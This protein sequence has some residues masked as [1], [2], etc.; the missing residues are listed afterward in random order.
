MQLFMPDN[1]KMII[2]RLQEAGYEAYAVGGCVRDSYLGK[3]PHDWDIT[4][5]ALPLEVKSLFRRTID[6]GIQHGTVKIMI[7]DEGYEVTTY[8]IDGEYEDNRHP[9][10]VIFTKSLEEDLK[11]R[12]FTINAMAYS[13]KTGIIDLFGGIEDLKI[14][15]IRA[16]GDPYERFSEDALRI[17]RALR[18]SAKFSFVIETKTR[19]A[20][21]ELA[22]TLSKI[23]AERIREEL[24]KMLMT[25]NPDRL[26]WAYELGVSK[27]IFPEWDDMM[28]CGQNTP[29]H[30][31]SAG[32]HTL[33]VIESLRD[34]YGQEPLYDQRILRIAGL[35]HDIAKPIMKTT[36][37]NGVDHF[38]GHPEKGVDLAKVILRRLKYDNDTIN[39]VCVLIKYHDVR[40]ILDL[41][42]VRKV[43]VK[44]GV[45]NF[46][47]LIKLKWADL[48]GQSRYERK[49]KEN[50]I[51]EL[52]RLYQEIMDAKDC[53][54]IKDLAVNGRDLIETGIPAGPELGNILDKM[55]ETVLEDPT[56][57]TREEL[58]KLLDVNK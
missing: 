13:E 8:R 17:L 23:S 56:R 41:K 40:P 19:Q 57:N 2:Q 12:D 11:R 45:E 52:E 4:T 35:L 18:F 26:C 55:L 37:A 42:H 16:V 51:I 5:S 54:S 38:K 48:E 14:G 6:V 33:R 31:Y 34:R 28:V 47:L 58:M 46:P 25:E 10:E 49:E 9:K 44:V 21:E 27:V 22:P 36:D 7:G 24:E 50:S 20:I 15:L 29:H 1:V 32:Y 53:L 30:I 43:V 39:K 3:T